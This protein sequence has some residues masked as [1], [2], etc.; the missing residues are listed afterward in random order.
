MAIK[1]TTEIH[2]TGLLNIKPAYANSLMRSCWYNIGTMWVREFRPKHFTEAG[3]HEYGYAPR[4]GESGRMSRKAFDKTYTGYKLRHYGHVDPLKYS[5]KSE[6]ATKAATINAIATKDRSGVTI[7]MNAPA[8]NFR[9]KGSPINMR[10]EMTELSENEK[11]LMTAE[12]KN[13][14]VRAFGGHPEA[15]I[16]VISTS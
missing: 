16:K 9:R 3:A 15:T 7:K 10:R 13:M 11:G 2:I 14:L 6:T 12:L 4:V 8:L 5:G 1:F